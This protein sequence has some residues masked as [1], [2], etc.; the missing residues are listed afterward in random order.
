M[1][2]DCKAVEQPEYGCPGGVSFEPLSPMKKAHD[3]FK[4]GHL[5]GYRGCLPFSRQ[6]FHN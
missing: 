3:F 6:Y 4:I 1:K 2:I 5:T